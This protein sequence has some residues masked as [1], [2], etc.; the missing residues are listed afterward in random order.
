MTF[1]NLD[2]NFSQYNTC[3][4][5]N[6]LENII[7]KIFDLNPCLIIRDVSYTVNNISYKMG[8]RNEAYIVWLLCTLWNNIQ[9]IFEKKIFKCWEEMFH[10]YMIIIDLTYLYTFLWIRSILVSKQKLKYT[11]VYF[12]KYHKFWKYFIL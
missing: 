8:Q 4:I 6:Y 9:I 5:N 1:I 3:F 12:N 2:I 10:D 11:K 7:K